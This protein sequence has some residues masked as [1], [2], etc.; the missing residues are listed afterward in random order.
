MNTYFSH[1]INS[2]IANCA[3]L[4]FLISVLQRRLSVALFRGVVGKEDDVA[5]DVVIVSET[6]EVEG[7]RDF[8]T[9]F[10]SYRLLNSENKRQ[11]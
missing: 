10:L 4:R 7:G 6:G 1:L 11:V 5:D 2:P 9:G 8:C 3:A